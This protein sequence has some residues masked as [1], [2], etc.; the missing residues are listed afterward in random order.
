MHTT[1]TSAWLCWTT[2]QEAAHSCS[3]RGH[4]VIRLIGVLQ[5]C[6]PHSA[7]EE[8]QMSSSLDI[9]CNAQRDLMQENLQE[10]LLA[11]VQLQHPLGA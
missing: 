5:I 6:E 11:L 1:G 9:P 10:L 7:I 2:T 4:S 3:N 8:A